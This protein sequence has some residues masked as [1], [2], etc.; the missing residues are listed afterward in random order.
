[1]AVI[2]AL[3]GSSA[4]QR[5]HG[6]DL[7]QHLSVHGGRLRLRPRGHHRHHFQQPDRGARREGGRSLPSPL[8]PTAWGTPRILN[9]AIPQLPPDFLMVPAISPAG[10]NSPFPHL[11]AP[12]FAGAKPTR[13]KILVLCHH[14]SPRGWKL[15]KSTF[16]PPSPPHRCHPHP[17]RPLG[18][19][20]INT[21][22]K[23]QLPASPK[24]REQRAPIPPPP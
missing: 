10:F 18:E 17:A 6:E 8:T 16:V 7:G 11:F 3:S 9:K 22:H 21:T 12:Y 2:P 19:I 14:P 4:R 5:R 23:A 15:K 20:N 1:M 13:P 24:G